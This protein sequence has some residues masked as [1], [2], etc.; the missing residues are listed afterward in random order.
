MTTARMDRRSF[1]RLTS[2]AGGGMLLS[3]YS[4][5]L[6]ALEVMKGLTV[7]VR[8]S[9]DY[10][11]KAIDWSNRIAK[12]DYH[13]ALESVGTEHQTLMTRGRP[14]MITQCSARNRCCWRLSRQPGATTRR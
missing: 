12:G 9:T 3:L 11:E 1:L 8:V 13:A 7:K 10:V 5:P 2:A 4:K 14:A 6:L